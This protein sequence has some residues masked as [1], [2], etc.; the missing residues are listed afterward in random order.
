[1]AFIDVIPYEQATG[2]LKEVYDQII[3]KRKKLAAVH[4]VQSLNPESIMAHMELYL[5]VMFA[6]SPLT[7][8]QREMI[9]VVVSAAN[10][11]EYCQEHHS[12]ALNNYW[13]NETKVF[14]LR[15]GYKDVALSNTDKMLCEFAERITLH[16]QYS[17][18]EKMISRLRIAGLDDRS[19]LDAALVIAYFNYVNRIVMAL[20]VELEDDKGTGYNY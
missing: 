17:Q 16:P 15:K 18:D 14:Q 19:I 4:M 7:R 11:C 1:M 2:R 6:Q 20:G 9:A 5:S 8:S 3:A 13:K 10:G 12:T